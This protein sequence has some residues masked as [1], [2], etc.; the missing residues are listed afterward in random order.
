ME[1]IAEVLGGRDV[2]AFNPFSNE[3]PEDTL[4]DREIV[5][6]LWQALAQ[7]SDEIMQR[8]ALSRYVSTAYKNLMD[9]L[10]FIVRNYSKILKHRLKGPIEREELKR[11]R[12]LSQIAGQRQSAFFQRNADFFRRQQERTELAH[13]DPGDDVESLLKVNRRKARGTFCISDV[14]E[15]T[16]T[17]RFDVLDGMADKIA[18]IVS[19]EFPFIKILRDVLRELKMTPDGTIIREH[20]DRFH[21]VLKNVLLEP[22]IDMVCRM[23]TAPQLKRYYQRDKMRTFPEAEEGAPPY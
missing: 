15:K 20:F 8:E 10:P 22:I 18:D 2:V 6:D 1:T 7:G 17:P 23:L 9:Q 3:L 11:P 16:K 19:T 14:R 13:R 5:L 21:E 12:A 4:G